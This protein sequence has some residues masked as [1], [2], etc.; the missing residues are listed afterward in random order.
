M[1][2]FI[3]DKNISSISYNN[4]PV[5]QVFYN[6]ILI[7]EAKFLFT[8]LANGTYAVSR[9][10]AHELT[11]YVQ[12]PATF[13]NAAVT[14]I[15]ANGFENCS[16][17]TNI[18]IPTSITILD[19]QAF[20]GC[21][22]LI[23]IEV[24]S[25]VTTIGTGAFENCSALQS[26]S[27]PFIGK[28]KN[29][30]LRFFGQIFGATS[31]DTQAA[32]VP[33]SLE[34]VEILDGMIVQGSA[35]KNCINLKSIAII[36]A[37]QIEA[38][39]LSGCTNLEKL[40]LPFIGSK[41]SAAIAYP[42][43]YI[44]GTLAYEGAVK[45]RQWYESSLAERIYVD[46]YIPEKLT[47]VV[48]AGG[49]ITAGA[50]QNCKTI[51]DI[52]L[53]AEVKSIADGSFA[54][55][56][57]ESLSIDAGLSV[58][59]D[60]AFFGSRLTNVYLPDSITE[61][62]ASAFNGCYIS[63]IT[64]PQ[65]LER[66]GSQAFKSNA[67]TCITLPDS[68]I[69]IE[70]GAFANC[71]ALET[72][73]LGDNLDSIPS[74]A[75]FMCSN[76][77]RIAIPASASSI[78]YGA[79]QYCSSL[80]AAEFAANSQ[81]RTIEAQAFN[82]CS[83]LAKLTI[84]QSVESIEAQAFSNCTALVELDLP[85][86]GQTASNNTF[87]G[88]LF[89][90]SNSDEQETFI[91]ESL[92]TVTVHNNLLSGAMKNCTNIRSVICA[93]G[94]TS[95][96]EDAFADCSALLSIKLPS[97]ITQINY[98]AFVGCSNLTDVFISDI[99]AW[100]NTKY[101]N[102]SACPLY[103][104]NN[105]Y[106]NNQLIT[107]LSI[108]DT[109]S[110]VPSYAFAKQASICSIHFAD[111]VQIIGSN[112]F[113][114][115]ST[116][117]EVHFGN[118]IKSIASSAFA[119]CINLNFDALPPN[120][121]SIGNYAFQSC[122]S[123]TSVTIP[124]GV[125]YIGSYAFNNCSSLTSVTIPNSVTGIGGYTFAACVS[126]TNI[127][128]PN[129]ITYIS[130]EAFAG[131]SSLTSVIIPD[132]VTS[133]A[134]RAF[135]KCS[136]LK[137]VYITDVAAWCNISFDGYFANPLRYA[138]NL[139]L[140]G[141]LITELVIP[142]SVTTIGNY[143]FYGCSKL[144]SVT[145]PDSVT[146]IGASFSG[147]SSLESITL[148]FV[149]G[150]R[151]TSGDTYQY[152]FGY[153]FGTSS[154]TNGVA[155]EQS[156]YGSS[157]SSTTSSTYYI[158]A[159][160]K[161]VTITGGNILYGAFYNCS[162]LT[163]I[164]IPD[165]VTSIGDVA[166]YYCSSLTSISIPD[167]VTSI[168]NSVFSGCSSLTSIA[169]PD[170]VT[171]I[172]YGAFSSCSSLTN[173]TIPDSVTSIG[174]R[175]LANCSKLTSIIIPD[176]VTNIG[177][178][179]FSN[180]TSLTSVT[181]GD[182][183]TSIGSYA[184]RNC[185]KL[186]E[187]RAVD[188]KNWCA[189]TFS[190]SYA[191][192]LYYAATM[193][194]ND[195]LLTD[196][197]IPTDVQAIKKF[198]FYN[199]AAI[200]NIS[201]PNNFVKIEESAFAKCS[202]L[203][204]IIV[205]DLDLSI[206]ADAFTDCSK[207]ERIYSK[208]LT[209]SLT[210]LDIDTEGNDQLLAC[211]FF[212]YSPEQL[213][214]EGQYWCMI[215][216]EIHEW[217][218]M[219]SGFAYELHAD[220]QG[221][222][223]NYGNP[224]SVKIFNIP[225][226]YNGL[227]I[228]EIAEGAF[229]GIQSVETINMYK[230]IA[231]IGNEAFADCSSLH[232]CKLSADTE[233]IGDKAF[234]H[235]LMLSSIEFPATAHSIGAEAFYNCEQLT[236]IHIDKTIAYIGDYAFA[237]CGNLSKAYIDGGDGSIPT[238]CFKD[239]AKLS[240]LTISSTITDICEEAF[241]GCIGLLQYSMPDS[242]T[243]IRKQAFS[244]CC[245]LTEI[246]LGDNLESL[247]NEAFIKCSGI[248][249]V[250][251]NSNKLAALSSTQNLSTVFSSSDASIKLI[252]GN[253]IAEIPSYLLDASDLAEGTRECINAVE[254]QE[255]AGCTRIQS[256]AFV[257]CTLLTTILLPNSIL[258][259]DA[260]AFSYCSN[261]TA[262]TLPK[263]L[264]TLGAYAFANCTNMTNLVIGDQLLSIG[265]NAFE[266]CSALK[267]LIIPN[268]VTSLG[269]SIM[270]GCTAI[271]HVTIPFVGN[272]KVNATATHFGYLFGASSYYYNIN[273]VPASLTEVT[274]TSAT[275]IPDYAFY[276]CDCI[277]DITMMDTIVSIG[278]YA[279]QDCSALTTVQLSNKLTSIGERAF[280]DC[281]KF[282][283][284]HLPNT[285]TSIGW[286]AFN[287]EKATEKNIFI[288]DI[289]AFC[290][291]VSR[292]F[293]ID[294][295]LYINEE[296]ITHLII[297]ETVAEITDQVF[298]G[299]NSIKKLSLPSTLH[300]LQGGEFMDCSNLSELIIP[301]ALKMY[302]ATPFDGSPIQYVYYLGTPA[303]WIAKCLNESDEL[304]NATKYYY[305]EF[306]PECPGQFWHY[307]GTEIKCWDTSHFNTYD[308]EY[309]LRNDIAEAYV[310]AYIG[311]AATTEIIDTYNLVSVSTIGANAF[312]NASTLTNI[313]L[314]N[315][316]TCIDAGAF[317]GCT[318]LTNIYYYGDNASW[319]ALQIGENNESFANAMV[320]YYSDYAPESEGNFWYRDADGNICKWP[321]L[322]QGLTYALNAD[323][324][325]YCISGIGTC[326]DTKLLLP[327]TYNALP[328]TKI[329]SSAFKNC[330]SITDVVISST[331]IE[332]E[333]AAFSGCT[334]LIDVVV[335]TNV[336]K[337]GLGVFTGC[338]NIRS[339]QLPF[340]GETLKN[341]TDTY[342]YP[343]GYIFGIDNYAGGVSTPQNYRGSNINT[344]TKSY[345]YIPSSLKSVTITGG[346]ILYG[347][348][349]N[350]SN[351]VEIILPPRITRIEQT[352][353]AFCTSLATIEL[354]NS[355]EYIATGAF[356]GSGIQS[357]SIPD[358]V[359]TIS[360]AA[361]T[362]CDQLTA[363]KIGSGITS[364]PLS[365]FA[366]C[367]N[368]KTVTLPDTLTA[369]MDAA[370]ENCS[371]LTTINIPASVTYIGGSAFLDCISLT[372]V[373]IT[374][375]AAWC[376]TYFGTNGNPL[377]Y[378]K[379]LYLNNELVTKVTIPEGITELS[380]G[381]F[382][383]YTTLTH[384]NLPSTL[385][386][387]GQNAFYGCA[388]LNNI[389]M[390]PGITSIGENAFGDTGQLTVGF[391]G[392]QQEW[393][394]LKSAAAAGNAK[395]IDAKV[396]ITILDANYI[397]NT[398]DQTYTLSSVNTCTIE[399]V[400]IPSSYNG[401]PVIAVMQAAF[402]DNEFIKQV[403]IS[404]GVQKLGYGVFEGCKN[405]EK[406]VVPNSV[407]SIGICIFKDCI[408][409]KE[410]ELPFLAG[411]PDTLIPEFGYLFSYDPRNIPAKLTSITINGA[412]SINESILENTPN[413]ITTLV[414]GDGVTGLGSS[415]FLP[416]AW[417]KLKHIILGKNIK[418]IG[419]AQFKNLTSLETVQLRGDVTTISMNAF[420]N[421][422]NLKSI[423]LPKSLKDIGEYA[424][425][426][427]KAL[428]SVDIPSAITEIDVGTWQNCTNLSTITIPKKIT[429]IEKA[430]FKGCTKLKQAV[431][432]ISTGWG[433]FVSLHYY[434]ISASALANPTT[435]AK[436]LTSELADKKWL[437]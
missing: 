388:N 53:G 275:T 211:T 403:T 157:T 42:F 124:D 421:C 408:Q 315:T 146:S 259:I 250:I 215:N 173:I 228:V 46:Y 126:L 76:L 17:I 310:S 391:A 328:V 410:L 383:K 358:S 127:A 389:S 22:G 351:L 172:S 288:S 145:I 112:A 400:V 133:I 347:A 120:I 306:E 9:N 169:I 164:T 225:A 269:Y 356:L 334:G 204:H 52:R 119:Y 45:L 292:P 299:C 330:S 402:A 174:P 425:Y 11:G 293:G 298:C 96:G 184:F 101:M 118:K 139:Y 327:A 392:A 155:T 258:N 165:S 32:Y 183:V 224:S 105:L 137:A 435:A 71:T 65:N 340:V 335:P 30:N 2:L 386:A 58:I 93:N 21:T 106:V 372:D 382:E 91:P 329:G 377:N 151:K 116:L 333:A 161:S 219:T 350:C 40:H 314:P 82:H 253:T 35:F 125:T 296:R 85:F 131:C 205:S 47:D 290:A 90:A 273:H 362:S 14:R 49:N 20:K 312:K 424:F 240:D 179:A 303:D 257:N 342:Q 111:T 19:T 272:L 279:F 336:Q 311:T 322:S 194:I 423:N 73:T 231:K 339:I 166:F 37:S 195:R 366:N 244:G 384:V 197:S 89:G 171:S 401:L 220:G 387:I 68:L 201:F 278:I 274:I 295:D 325:S 156:Y 374:D 23:S 262:M 364:I 390:Y 237:N 431:F 39:A 396:T 229:K 213:Y 170:S 239:C 61:I 18:Q 84:P 185:S 432:E 379:N 344:T 193:Y 226:S 302:S 186:C 66:L 246:V 321:P 276:N 337:I 48:I 411:E 196:L 398:A 286:F 80:I 233:L 218:M 245:N 397:L 203:S 291:I 287:G 247:E 252:I 202:N 44:F 378:A 318:Q 88:Y 177:S 256:N 31:S 34:T 353:F 160:L 121:S 153:I 51:K 54:Q 198:A 135:Y 309:A 285:L 150:S 64:L 123:L 208:T 355:V 348:F 319:Q 12:I 265:D 188:L 115:C 95:I 373:H 395:L 108:P 267:Q 212:L 103:Y 143:A 122:S 370:F 294:W 280:Y 313:I 415:A 223:L 406:V 437:R 152:P 300:G 109:V 74:S 381:I 60:H 1:P 393:N 147:C 271:E 140:N 81:C 98:N 283:N 326:S 4:Y 263:N 376:S 191:N 324:I 94:V 36:S 430:A 13:N 254:F 234:A 304:S 419:N 289:T 59:N 158:P 102:D 241:A 317:A 154:Y 27:L 361:F 209:G 24:P 77:K 343:L 345:Y 136:N 320:Y 360:M 41:L 375:I 63:N 162:K 422:Q 78:G 236:S 371:N 149:G 29:T 436:Y 129:N 10:P 190:N 251:F 354:P 79:F 363:I 38:G 207:L 369:I 418:Y 434:S 264:K 72:I 341:S 55:A 268:S 380:E 367:Y 3:D 216:D 176:N 385:T 138:K 200:T 323:N 413:N 110:N 368:L 235:C 417:P 178:Y 50:F 87:I 249:T 255:T 230:N 142:D 134:Y 57:L 222:I 412:G 357:I 346:N 217:T 416:T 99:A 117:N 331:I 187:V 359:T 107:D 168:G 7:Y 104:A 86:I 128:I 332:I 420:Y 214:V 238:G 148:P 427:C 25:S 182:S 167:G 405:L 316:I 114:Y 266:S 297:P 307:E 69:K 43:G 284:I 130:E 5:E 67:F 15:A 338:G 308:I 62:G 227:P 192:P 349:Y 75:F 141:E 428:A 242:L 433:Y 132:S 414:V 28:G 305:S 270:T 180:C 282:I 189:I 26:I 210:D 16:N 83:A 144:T 352:A 426:N 100:C 281:E 97:S 399:N 404:H 365:L 394:N 261:L 56:I 277:T 113:S 70:S 6:D 163:S 409:L 199:C 33:T 301:A 181:I 248:K 8:Q 221:Y 407:S 243:H 175:M 206:A 159:S 429:T 260:H 92:C 232:T